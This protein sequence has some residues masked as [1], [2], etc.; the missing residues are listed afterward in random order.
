MGENNQ[1]E[2]S[3]GVTKD[4]EDIGEEMDS[5]LEGIPKESRHEVRKLVGMSMQIFLHKWN[6]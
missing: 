4:R 6:L 5:I 1:V 3:K 2:E